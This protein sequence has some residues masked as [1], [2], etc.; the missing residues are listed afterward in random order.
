[1]IM[2]VGRFDVTPEIYYRGGVAV[3]ITTYC[4]LDNI[5]RL[6]SEYELNE[7]GTYTERQSDP[8]NEGSLTSLTVLRSRLEELDRNSPKGLPF[9]TL[10]G[11]GRSYVE[12]VI[13]NSDR[14]VKHLDD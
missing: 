8:Q 5:D 13:E 6:I 11:K 1:M 10:L 7:D 2:K 14:D 4:V 9:F 12:E 3:R